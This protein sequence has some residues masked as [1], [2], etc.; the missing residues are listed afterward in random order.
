MT[1]DIYFRLA[2]ALFGVVDAYQYKAYRYH[3]QHKHQY[4]SMNWKT[5]SSI[6]S[7]NIIKNKFVRIW[8]EDE[9]MTIYF[10]LGLLHVDYGYFGA[11]W[12]PALSSLPRDIEMMNISGC[13]SCLE[14]SSLSG[15]VTNR[16]RSF[17]VFIVRYGKKR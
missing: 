10:L 13:G 11:N 12:S 17:S 4:N 5:F 9:N 15:N 7:D 8:G 3:L 1:W 6:I 16:T 2:T 14:L